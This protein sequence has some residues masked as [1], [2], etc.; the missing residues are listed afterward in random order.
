MTT[1]APQAQHA[2]PQARLAGPKFFRVLNSEWGKLFSL[3][4]TRVLALCTMLL[5]I[6]FA[7]IAAWGVGQA[8]KA[9]RN[10]TGAGPRGGGPRGGGPGGGFDSA[11]AILH[12]PAAGVTFAQLIVGA[13][14]ILLISS[15][16]STGM[17]RATFAA[18]PRRWPVLAAKGVYGIIVGFALTYLGGYLGGL[19]AQPILK[20]YNLHL[21]MTDWTVQ[22]YLLLNAAYVAAVG[23][24]GLALGALLRNSAGAIV[25]LVALLFVLP[26]IFRLI[27]GDFFTQAR[28]YLPSNAA[29]A[30]FSAGSGNPANAANLQPWQGT[31]VLAGYVVVLLAAAFTTLKQRD[32]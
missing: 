13:L 9:A 4:S 29:D 10:G 31:L 2:A 21:D 30:M 28:K 11:Q 17:A 3:L 26:I 22:R 25:A 24:I 16:F 20:H 19:L 27:P 7:A 8:A 6:G 14:V 18:V 23:L 32:V 12:L 5:M 15:E 1:A